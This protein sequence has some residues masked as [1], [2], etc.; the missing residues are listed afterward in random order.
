MYTAG[1]GGL[2]VI[3]NTE[4]RSVCGWALMAMFDRLGSEHGIGASMPSV[5]VQEYCVSSN[6]SVNE[7]SVTV[8]ASVYEY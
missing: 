6:W 2:S 5:A 4:M 3:T 1:S 7:T 8:L